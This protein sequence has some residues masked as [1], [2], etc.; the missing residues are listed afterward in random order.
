MRQ[1]VKRRGRPA[2]GSIPEALDMFR[3]EVRFYR[4]IAPVVGVRVPAC[5]RAEITPDGTALVL[6]DLS[7]WAPGA[8]PVA[9]AQVLSGLHRRW[10]GTAPARWPWLRPVGAAVDLVGALY[11]RTWPRLAERADLPGP[12]RVLGNRL[13]GRLPEAVRQVRSA[14]PP[15][16]VHGDSS[17]RNVRTGT[18]GVIALLDWED[19][20]AAPGSVDLAWLLLSSVPAP[21]WDEVA[22]AYGDCAGLV[23]VLPAVV[24]QGLLTVAGTAEGS[25]EA[26]GWAERLAEAERRLAGDNLDH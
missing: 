21:R 13:V 10:A 17:A 16:L 11:D 26:R 15:T 14:G 23:T 6:E 19:V 4:E 5:H 9:H 22:A 18:D 8:D 2:P 12:V 7:D 3:A 20:S 25:A 24:V 1:F